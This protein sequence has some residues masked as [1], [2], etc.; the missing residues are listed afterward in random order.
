MAN[1]ISLVVCDDSLSNEINK[2]EEN[3]DFLIRH[4]I[5]KEDESIKK[6]SLFRFNDF[7]PLS[8]DTKVSLLGKNHRH[9][10]VPELEQA[11]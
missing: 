1:K 4:F 10:S 8:E 7:E 9:G 6:Y 11:I 2:K 5:D 3:N